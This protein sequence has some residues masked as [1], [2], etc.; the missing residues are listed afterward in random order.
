MYMYYG[1]KK[2]LIP[3][4]VF[5]LFPFFFISLVPPVVMATVAAVTAIQ[6]DNLTLTCIAID[7]NP[8][9]I[10][11][12][13]RNGTVVP[14]LATPTYRLEGGGSVLVIVGV[15]EGD[16]GTF[17]CSASSPAGTD[18]DS[19]TLSVLGKRSHDPHMT[20]T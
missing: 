7:G 12:W 1:M 4:T 14:S 16:E 3:S 13:T 18:Q 5:T 20:I 10:W 17:Q 11:S 6:G 19:I 9:P 2:A 8:V 15:G